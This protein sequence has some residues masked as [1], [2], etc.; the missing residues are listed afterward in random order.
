MLSRMLSIGGSIRPLEPLLHVHSDNAT[1]TTAVAVS[2]ASPAWSDQ[3]AAQMGVTRMCF[4]I[5]MVK[6]AIVLTQH[7]QKANWCCTIFFFG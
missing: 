7:G 1:S 3:F 5:S 6:V 4:Q 2:Q